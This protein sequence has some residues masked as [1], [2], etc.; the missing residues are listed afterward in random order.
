VLSLCV[1]SS[2]ANVANSP[3]LAQR[4]ERM[5]VIVYTTPTCGFCAQLKRYLDQRRIPFVEY[6]VSQDPHRATEMV[7]IS[8]QQGVPVSIVDGQVVLGADIPRIN[9]LLA[10]RA[11]HPPKLGI[12]IADAKRI[13][14]KKGTELPGGA[15]IGRVSPASAAGRAGL[16]PGDVIVK[17]AGRPI[18][19]DQDVH[20][21]GADLRYDQ[22]VDLQFWRNG[23]TIATKVL[24]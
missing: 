1:V 15:Y 23:Q 18:H 10:Q 5:S 22:A 12:A 17:L 11:G 2:S 13:A 24:P 16:R 7:R 6:D 4:T 20:R 3:S 14:A 8:G 21:V 9:Q 19:S